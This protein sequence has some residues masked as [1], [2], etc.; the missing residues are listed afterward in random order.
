MSPKDLEGRKRMVHAALELLAE[1]DD[2]STITIRQVASRAGVG[3][4]LINYHFHNKENLLKQAIDS[5]MGNLSDQWDRNLDASIA[6]PIQRMKKILKNN[7]RTA[8]QNAKYMR[9]IIRYELLQGDFVTSQALLP[10]LREIYEQS[11]REE[12]IRMIAFTLV[13]SMQVAFLR[14][15]AFRAYSGI[16]LDDPIQSDRLVDELVD[17]LVARKTD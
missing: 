16:R 11:K 5:L 6:D 3:V 14:E 4:G 2:P 7:V 1:A 15:K 17:D 13:S 8:V 10:V 12:E 9:I